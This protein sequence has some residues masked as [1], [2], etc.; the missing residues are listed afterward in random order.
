MDE[1]LK[2]LFGLDEDDSQEDAVDPQ[3]DE[4]VTDEGDEPEEAESEEV[5]TPQ[6]QSQ[7]DNRIAAQARREA[8]QRMRETDTKRLEAEK[9]VDVLLK[10]LNDYGYEGTPEEIADGLRASKSGRTIEEERAA[11]LQAE[12]EFQKLIDNHPDVVAAR[13]QKAQQDRNNS[14]NLIQRELETIHKK[15]PDITSLADLQNLGDDQ[16]T[17][18]ALIKGGIHI[19][20]AYDIIMRGKEPNRPKSS[21]KSHLKT[22]NGDS[23]DGG[24]SIVPPRERELIKDMMPGITDKEINDWYKKHKK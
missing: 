9:K 6:H 11:R 20:K 18:D 12:Q 19:D 13:E 15:Y 3:E 1:E 10:A 22:V 2:E 21:T 23:H 4:D 16:E 8:E 7:E 17:F 14:I 5:A 24:S